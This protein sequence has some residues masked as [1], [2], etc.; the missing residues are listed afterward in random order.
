LLLK[1]LLD[2]NPLAYL[3]LKHFLDTNIHAYLPLKY[4]LTSIFVAE[5]LSRNEHTS[6]FAAETL[7]SHEHTSLCAAELF[8]KKEKKFYKID[9]RTFSGSCC[10]TLAS[11]SA[12]S[13]DL[14]SLMSGWR[15]FQPGASLASSLTSLVLMMSA[16]ATSFDDLNLMFIF[17]L[18]HGRRRE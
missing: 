12:M 13:L 3:L 18:R 15:P 10:L 8:K 2:T 4:L 1:H 14:Q 5:T 11:R 6:L 9:T 16:V 7:V 17:F